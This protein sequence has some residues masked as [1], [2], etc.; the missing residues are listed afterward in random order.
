VVVVAGLLNVPGL[1]FFLQDNMNR[2]LGPILVL[3][4]L[5]LLTPFWLRIRGPE[6]GKRLQSWVE[7]S[8][9]WGALA[10]GF[11]FALSFCPVSA[12]LFFGSLIPLAVNHNSSILMPSIYG[13]GTALPVVGFSLLIALG[14]RFVGAVFDRLSTIE[15]WAR[16]LTGLI[17][18][19]VGIHLIITYLI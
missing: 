7:K 18:V 10:L 19:I 15:R 11:L 1:S 5:F 4:G 9:L 16:R 8:G 3:I 6:F 17:F 12:A 2:I 13:I 14:A